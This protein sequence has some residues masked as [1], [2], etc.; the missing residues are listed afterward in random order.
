MIDNPKLL[1]ALPILRD[2]FDKAQLKH[3]TFPDNETE[4]STVMMEELGEF[5]KEVNDRADG[6]RERAL[7]E[8]AHVAVTAIRSMN[9][10]MKKMEAE[11]G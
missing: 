5:S 1:S 9:T 8:A 2:E 7:T 10:L 11:N 4:M 6:W 3:P